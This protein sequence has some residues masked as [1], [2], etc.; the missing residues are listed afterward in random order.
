MVILIMLRTI[1]S[2][3]FEMLLY[4]IDCLFCSDLEV[5]LQLSF[6]ML[7]VFY[8]CLTLLVNSLS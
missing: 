1:I 8:S 3:R 2:L 6:E 7:W 5:L 4:L